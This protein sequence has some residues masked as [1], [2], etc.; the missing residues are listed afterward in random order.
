MRQPSLPPVVS[1]SGAHPGPDQVGSREAF[2]PLT[3]LHPAD[4]DVVD[5]L[6]R[7]SLSYGPLLF[8]L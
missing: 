5:S 1:P 2:V 3:A 4:S 6:L 7:V 8:L